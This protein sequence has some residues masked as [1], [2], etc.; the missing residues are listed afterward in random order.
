MISVL[1]DLWVVQ[2]NHQ[3]SVSTVP[4]GAGGSCFGIDFCFIPLC[5]GDVSMSSTK[6]SNEAI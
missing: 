3:N 4:Y 1:A 6:N 5:A 2:V